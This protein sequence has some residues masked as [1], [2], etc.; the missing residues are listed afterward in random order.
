MAQIKEFTPVTARYFRFTISESA[1]NPQ[2][3][4]LELYPQL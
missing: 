2:I 3:R 1:K 4:D